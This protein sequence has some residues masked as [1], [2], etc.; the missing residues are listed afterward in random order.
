[1]RHWTLVVLC[2]IFMAGCNTVEGFG[3]DVEKL[4]DKIERKAAEKRN[5]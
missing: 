1:M 5:Y 2:M 4:G 3:R